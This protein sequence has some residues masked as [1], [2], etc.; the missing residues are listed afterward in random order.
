MHVVGLRG[1]DHYMKPVYH[2]VNPSCC[3]PMPGGAAPEVWSISFAATGCWLVMG[4]QK[5]ARHIHQGR[6][7][8]LFQGSKEIRI[9]MEWCC[10]EIWDNW[11]TC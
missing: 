7:Q 8:R 1:L 10:K 4:A 11:A 6:H 5:M 3:A 2:H 9:K